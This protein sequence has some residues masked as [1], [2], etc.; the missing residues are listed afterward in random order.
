MRTRLLIGAA[1]VVLFVVLYVLSRV[2]LLSG[3]LR[4]EDRSVRQ[5][6]GRALSAV[7]EELAQLD[8]VAKDWAPW[9][10]TYRFAMD[11]NPAY[12]A[13]NLLP[14]TFANLRLDLML[15]LDS[16]GD[17]VY[18][19]AADRDAGAEVPFPRSL[20]GEISTNDLLLRH[21]DLRSGTTG[22]LV[23]PEGAL[24]VVSRAIL[25]SLQ[26]GPS[27]GSLIMG[28]FLNARE[29]QRLAEFIHLALVVRKAGESP[30]PLPK[31]E[32]IV[33]SHLT[34]RT[35]A[36]LALLLDL[37]G[38]PAVVIEVDMPRDIYEQGKT[39]VL[40]MLISLGV[41][42]IVFGA[43]F[44]LLLE[45]QVLSRLADL[46][47]AVRRAGSDL[48]TRVA[49]SE[50]DE[51]SA[52]AGEINGMLDRIDETQGRLR[53]SEAQYRSLFEQSRDPIYITT[54]AGEFVDI[55]EAGIELFGY[56]SEEIR[57][58]KAQQLYVNPKERERFQEEMTSAGF[59]REYAVRLRK[60]DGREMD[61]LL[62]TT[63]RRAADGSVLD[64][65][66]I[67]R[68]IT[69]KKRAEARLAYLATHDALTGLPNRAA[70]AE[71]LA[72]ELAHA[73][74]NQTRVAVMLLDLDRFKEVNDSL[75]HAVGDELLQAVAERLSGGLRKSDTVARLGGDE[76]LVLLPGADHVERSLGVAQKIVHALEQPFVIA[77]REV[78]LTVSIGLALYP[79][80]GR[81]ADAL[82]KN[83]DTAM[84]RA[85]DRGRNTYERFSLGGDRAPGGGPVPAHSDGEGPPP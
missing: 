68:D 49:I 51:L 29:V 75:G 60:K 5:N 26:E 34:G 9:D 7:S 72:L 36:G 12:V 76:F 66:G 73:E 83:A 62:T 3:F 80:D 56:T 30:L 44:L 67:V 43:V 71:R 39:T 47:A 79:D 37:Y 59:V 35:V 15:F 2:F 27:S 50:R 38:K 25:T 17:V 1:V 45:R 70:F 28:R 33:V 22:I 64:Y 18:A 74:R 82:I 41:V 54:P 57:N 42:G 63:A 13:A 19:R 77:G 16:S 81:D 31:P 53:E 58:L 20:L 40:T 24:L 21:P 61:C 48:A 85:K 69:E 84:Y 14:S 32:S 46:G 55:N 4:L 8:S 65:R 52:L 11:R 23:L 78:R 6:V 10:D